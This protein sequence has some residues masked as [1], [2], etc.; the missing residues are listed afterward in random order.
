MINSKNLFYLVYEESSFLL[1]Y[2]PSIACVAI[3]AVDFR[4]FKPNLSHFFR[5]RT[6]QMQLSL[7]RSLFYMLSLLELAME[8]NPAAFALAVASPL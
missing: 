3:V 4:L 7:F 5:F 8:Q 6:V 1:T 2:I